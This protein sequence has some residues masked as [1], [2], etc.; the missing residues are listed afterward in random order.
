MATARLAVLAMA[1]RWGSTD[2]PGRLGRPARAVRAS[3]AAPA[4]AARSLRCCSARAAVM[5]GCICIALSCLLGRA[6]PAGRHT[7]CAACGGAGQRPD[8]P[9]LRAADAGVELPTGKLAGDRGPVWL[10]QTCLQGKPDQVSAAPSPSAC[11]ACPS[12]AGFSITVRGTSSSSRPIPVWQRARQRRAATSRAED[13]G[14]LSSL[15]PIKQRLRCADQGRRGRIGIDG[16]GGTVTGP[17][18]A[19]KVIA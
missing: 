14:Q 9:F 8:Y 12:I 4:C 16:Y 6:P 7:G 19:I 11:R 2:L 1:G 17:L 15:D 5:S 3:L 10:N 18:W 13:S